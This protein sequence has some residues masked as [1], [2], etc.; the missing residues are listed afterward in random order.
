MGADVVRKPAGWSRSYAVAESAG[1]IAPT[2]Q[3]RRNG[4]PLRKLP[5]VAIGYACCR[6]FLRIAHRHEKTVVSGVITVDPSTSSNQRSVWISAATKFLNALCKKFQTSFR[7]ED[8]LG[9]WSDEAEV[10]L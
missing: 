1:T 7:Q 3:P 2:S 4:F 8:R 5:I 6:P 10:V 9:R